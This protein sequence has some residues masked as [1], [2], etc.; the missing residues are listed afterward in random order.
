MEDKLASIKGF[1][2]KYNQEHILRWYDELKEEEKDEL[3]GK[4]SNIDFELLNSIYLKKDKKIDIFNNVIEP[5]KVIDIKEIDNEQLNRYISIGE[6]SICN[7]EYAVVTMAGGQ[8]TRLGHNGP[9]GTFML[10]LD[11]PKSIFEILCNKFKRIQEKY[12]V[13]LPWYIM[14]SNQ[15][16]NETVS[17]FEYNKYFGYPKEA[18]T[19]FPQGELPMLDESG[20]ILMEE[21]WKI[22]EGPDGNGGI[23]EALNKS[24]IINKLNEENIKWIY[25]GGVD[26]ILAN[27]IDLLLLGM[28]IDKGYELSSKS[29]AKNSPEEKG[30]VFCRK[31]GKVSVINYNEMTQEMSMQTNEQGDLV[32]GDMNILS[33]LFSINALNKIKDTKLEYH[34][35]YKKANYI[36]EAGNKVIVDSPN[37]YKFETYMF[38]CLEL[39]DDM[40]VL[41][42]IREKEFAPIKNKD[43]VDSPQTATQMYLNSI[44]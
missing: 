25:V 12:N 24:G 1:L 20:R 9:K 42:S 32:Y 11:P 6:K 34:V 28:T 30:G 18:I 21:K 7:N 14:T 39:F 40:L 43:G 8:G 3:L 41:R 22:K 31:N 16:H 27:V 35:D 37:A 15:N 23:F 4:V 19:F 26:N 2:E 10:Q 44:K 38:D 13:I 33:H 36:D 17:F 29:I 5:I